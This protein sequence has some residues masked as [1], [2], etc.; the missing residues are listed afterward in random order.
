VSGLLMSDRIVNS[1][2]DSL[3]AGDVVRV[4]E[5]SPPPNESANAS[6]IQ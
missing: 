2:P 6:A 3:S 4:A 1:P 5:Q